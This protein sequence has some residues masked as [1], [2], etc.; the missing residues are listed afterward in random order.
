MEV[1]Y[2][3]VIEW[4]KQKIQARSNGA[5]ILHGS[6]VLRWRR[7]DHQV[8]FSEVELRGHSTFLKE[9]KFTPDVTTQPRHA[10][11]CRCQ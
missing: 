11:N 5:A 2:G 10:D 3:M 1:W 8:P 6:I 7:I 4:I 9:V